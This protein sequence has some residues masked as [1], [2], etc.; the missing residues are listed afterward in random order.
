MA[1]EFS[2]QNQRYEFTDSYGQVTDSDQDRDTLAHRHGVTRL[3]SLDDEGWEI[4]PD[5]LE[6][7]DSK[8][9]LDTILDQTEAPCSADDYFELGF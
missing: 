4:V 9:W 7:E 5:D 3:D 6:G 2:A 1:I 8:G